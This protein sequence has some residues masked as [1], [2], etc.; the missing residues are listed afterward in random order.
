MVYSRTLHQPTFPTFVIRSPL[1]DLRG[2]P[3]PPVQLMNL[4]EVL[5]LSQRLLGKNTHGPRPKEHWSKELLLG[6]GSAANCLW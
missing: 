4:P 5:L 1:L 6:T 3:F 2:V